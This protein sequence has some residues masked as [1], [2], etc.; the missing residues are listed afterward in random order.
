AADLEGYSAA[1]CAAILREAALTAMRESLD[2]SEVTAAH[3]AQA[4]RNVPP[5]LDPFQVAE[6]EAYA[7][8]RSAD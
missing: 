4:R 6:L 5:S 1:D 2:A 3:L 8:R 7:A